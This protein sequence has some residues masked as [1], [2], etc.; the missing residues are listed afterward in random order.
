MTHHHYS[1]H[2]LVMK[3]VIRAPAIAQR[4]ASLSIG[5]RSPGNSYDPRDHYA[6]FVGYDAPYASYYRE[7]VWGE[8]QRMEEG[9]R[10]EERQERQRI[11][12]QRR[13]QEE[14]RWHHHKDDDDDDD[15]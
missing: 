7:S 15:D 11:W 5:T 13:R 3:P 8:R 6:P 4:S 14:H 1:T 10:W 9:R 2:H 12:E